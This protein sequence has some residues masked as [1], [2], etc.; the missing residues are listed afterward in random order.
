MADI[1]SA[2]WTESDAG[3]TAAPPDGWPE[4]QPA[5]SVNNCARAIMGGIRR[6]YDRINATVTSGGS[7]N[8]HTLTYT[9]PPTALVKGDTFSFVAGFTNTGA[10]TLNVGVGGALAVKVGA[11]DLVA[12]VI[13]AGDV[14]SVAYDGSIFQFTGW[15]PSRVTSADL[16][17]N[18]LTATSASASAINASG[19]GIHA[20][21]NVTLGNFIY[22]AGGGTT[23]LYGDAT[24]VVSR[25]G[26]G[27]GFLMQNNTGS[28][29]HNFSGS[30]NATHS[31]TL[32]VGG[33]GTFG[34]LLSAPDAHLTVATI[35]GCTFGSGTIAAANVTT[36]GLTVFGN[37][38][39]T[40]INTN[41]GGITTAGLQVN[42]TA[43]VTGAS[44]IG[45]VTTATLQVNGNAGITGAFSCDTISCS[46]VNTNAGGITTA[47]L[48]VN[49]AA[50][51]TGN[52]TLSGGSL[53]V[54]GAIQAGAGITCANTGVVYSNIGA[55]GFNFRWDGTHALVRI[56]NAVEY[57]IYSA[58][59]GTIS[60]AINVTGGT[61]TTTLNVANSGNS[62]TTGGNILAGNDSYAT[63]VFR[64]SA[65]TGARIEAWGGDWGYMSFAKT[66][67]NLLISPDNGVTGFVITTD[68]SFSDAKLKENI[69]DTQVD[70][71]AAIVATPIR[72]FD[73]N[74]EG[75]R[76]MP[77]A[78]KTVAIGMV[79]QE[80]QETMPTTVG[81]TELSGGTYHLIDTNFTPYLMRAIQ[82]IADRLTALENK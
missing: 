76:I 77:Y 74:A 36:T 31:G 4:G 14:V 63:N 38:S 13:T 29:T 8:A 51:V 24:N 18:T 39:C 64:C 2:L 56:D 10:T 42:G 20:A 21:G 81:Y 3:N 65:A 9:V 17:V 26:V 54:F 67:G 72:Q 50:G 37:T 73:W 16:T 40:N 58:S 48:Q 59:G 33:T 12:G 66:P 62:L 5:N 52:L 78:D 22:F 70:A 55:N 53:S 57:P 61:T 69:K 60:G 49:G 68:G 34:G 46:T 71:L 7:A 30:G 1:N 79:A 25:A 80:L 45:S 23:Y 47:G 44:T 27:G 19:G 43:V 41:S 15:S 35:G 11:T 75:L 6:F 28:T 32:N 82:Q